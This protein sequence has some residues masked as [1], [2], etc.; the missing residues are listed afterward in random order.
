[1]FILSLLPG[2]FPT[3][4]PFGIS[5]FEYNTREEPISFR[6]QAEDYLDLE[7]RSF[8]YHRSF[9]FIALNIFQQHSPHLHSAL[10][11]KKSNYDAVAQRLVSLT[12]EL[13]ESVAKDMENEGKIS[14]LSPQEMNVMTLLK[15]VSAV[16]AKIPGS[17]ASKLHIRNEIRAYMGYFCLPHL[18]LTLNPN[19]SHS[20]IFQVIYGDDMVDLSSRYP[21]LV[22]SAERAIRLASDPVAGADF[23][24]FSIKSI[25]EH[26]L[27]WL[28]RYHKMRSRRSQACTVHYVVATDI[29][30]GPRFGNNRWNCRATV[31]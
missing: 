13:I 9:I 5:G 14:E 26:L 15:E 3:L 2:M 6:A 16:S 19:A 20:P 4:F 12:P 21:A 18:Y 1:L 10:T 30:H 7:D 24:D 11:V 25:F 8:R 29:P 31:A 27:G 23:F 22:E 28:A 17:S